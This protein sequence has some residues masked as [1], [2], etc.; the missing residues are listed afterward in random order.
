VRDAAHRPFAATTQLGRVTGKYGCRLSAKSIDSDRG[1]GTA[2]W[3][4]RR[5]EPPCT[6]W[7]AGAVARS[8]ERASSDEGYTISSFLNLAIG[9]GRARPPRAALVHRR[10]DKPAR[11]L[12]RDSAYTCRAGRRAAVTI[13]TRPARVSVGTSRT[14]ARRHDGFGMRPPLARATLLAW[15]LLLS[16]NAPAL[17]E[18]AAA[19][20][21]VPGGADDPVTAVRRF[22]PLT[23]HLTRELDRPVKLVLRETYREVLDAFGRD[24]VDIVFGNAINFVQARQRYGARALVKRVT[25]QGSGDWPVPALPHRPAR[26]RDHRVSHDS[27]Q[28]HRVRQHPAP[29]RGVDG[30][31]ARGVELA[32]LRCGRP[33]PVGDGGHPP[34]GRRHHRH[35]G[36]TARGRPVA[37]RGGLRNARGSE[38]AGEAASAPPASSDEVTGPR[39]S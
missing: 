18:P 38:V 23:E 31:P 34:Q 1:L 13:E 5:T 24:E 27:R 28:P 29:R 35:V 33:A 36:G 6:S 22:E 8:G 21:I 17:A 30:R 9:R 12:G 32:R 11:A 3:C 14:G 25:D 16:I 7:T 4:R 10:V 26:L 20:R 15:C 39:P 19:L 37:A 2:T